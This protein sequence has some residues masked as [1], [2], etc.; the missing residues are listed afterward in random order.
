[1]DV[2]IGTVERFRYSKYGG[3]AE[4]LRNARARELRK[5]GFVVKCKKWSFIDLARDEVYQLEV[6][7][8]EPA[9]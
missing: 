8:H 9:A 6:T 2:T 5:L 4:R 7:R 3:E 1:M